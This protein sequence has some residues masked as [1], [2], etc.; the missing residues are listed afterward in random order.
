MVRRTRVVVGWMTRPAVER[1]TGVRARCRWGAMARRTR[2]NAML[3]AARVGAAHTNHSPVIV[4]SVTR[5]A[6]AERKPSRGEVDAMEVMALGVRIAFRVNACARFA[7][8][9][10]KT[11]MRSGAGDSHSEK[12]RSPASNYARW[13]ARDSLCRP[14]ALTARARDHGPRRTCRPDRGMWRTPRCRSMD[15]CWSW[16][17]PAFPEH[18]DNRGTQMPWGR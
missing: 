8:T 16:R 5:A 11:G 6:I 7:I 2:L 14:D 18:R 4:I 12:K 3:V 1:M 9:L 10:D 13:R 15:R 17:V